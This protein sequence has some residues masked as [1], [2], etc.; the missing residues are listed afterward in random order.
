M[1]NEKIELTRKEIWELALELRKTRNEYQPLYDLIYEIN[2]A[3]D[4]INQLSFD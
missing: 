1:S 2:N 3:L 4:K